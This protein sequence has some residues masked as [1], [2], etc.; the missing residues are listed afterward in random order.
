MTP[1]A[2]SDTDPHP[3][4]AVWWRR[5]SLVA[6][7]LGAVVGCVADQP[8]AASWKDECRQQT[9]TVA[10]SLAAAD[11]VATLAGEGR[12]PGRYAAVAL[13]Q[14]EESADKAAT[15]LAALQ[16]PA[17]RTR[18]ARQIVAVVDRAV[19]AIREAR[20]E[21]VAHPEPSGRTAA[22]LHEELREQRRILARSP[23]ASCNS[24]DGATTDVATEARDG[25]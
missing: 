25:R 22:A 10:S 2:P 20:V 6:A 8:S 19:A 23:E 7:L 5:I 24:T 4:Y 11:R 14:S 18:S 16:P 21:I 17:S 12:L 15:S 13:V 3:T 9:S 1:M